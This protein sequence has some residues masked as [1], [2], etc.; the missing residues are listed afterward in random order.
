MSVER[1]VAQSS[2]SEKQT[3]SRLISQQILQLTR[4]RDLV[5]IC[6]FSVTGLLVSLWFAISYAIPAAD[7]LVEM[8]W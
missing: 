4:D 1:M 2:L 8:P 5:V 6:L 3:V 7:T